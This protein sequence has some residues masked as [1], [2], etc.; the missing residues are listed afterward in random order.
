MKILYRP[1]LLHCSQFPT[2]KISLLVKRGLSLTGVR[3]LYIT[4]C[5]TLSDQ[6]INFELP[7]TILKKYKAYRSRKSWVFDNRAYNRN[8]WAMISFWNNT[9]YQDFH[10]NYR[11][12]INFHYSNKYCREKLRKD[13]MYESYISGL[14]TVSYFFHRSPANKTTEIATSSI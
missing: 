14:P 1:R 5:K 8:P 3:P 6:T 2:L 13:C 11:V 12:H 7:S 9:T 10:L 4:T